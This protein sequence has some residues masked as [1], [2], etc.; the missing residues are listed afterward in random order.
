M[1]EIWSRIS[2][3]LVHLFFGTTSC[4]LTSDVGCYTRKAMDAYARLHGSSHFDG[5]QAN[6]LQACFQRYSTDTLDLQRVSDRAWEGFVALGVVGSEGWGGD[7]SWIEFNPTILPSI[8]DSIGGDIIVA[9]PC[10][11]VSNFA[12]YRTAIE[13]C[14]R[15]PFSFGNEQVTR[16]VVHTL[17]N[18]AFGSTFFHSSATLTGGL[19]DVRPI[20]LLALLFHQLAVSSLPYDPLLFDLSEIPR[21]ET[22]IEA[23]DTL[24][25]IL[26]EQD[27]SSWRTALAGMDVPFFELTFSAFVGV[28]LNLLFAESTAAGIANT[29]A[30]LLLSEESLDFVNNRVFPTATAAVA[31]VR[32]SLADRADLFLKFIGTGI[33]MVRR[34][35]RQSSTNRSSHLLYTITAPCIFMA[36]TSSGWFNTIDRNCHAKPVFQCT[37]PT[38]HRRHQRSFE[39][40]DSLSK[41]DCPAIG[42]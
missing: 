3:F 2:N 42:Y 21:T 14:E 24:S 23:A 29:T 41:G 1:G 40:F 34:I 13:V 22:G 30:G 35:C 7:G 26:L 39:L 10:N 6:R 33:K 18:L 38:N 12:Y 9:E 27:P 8:D 4:Q 15:Q 31:D 19:A 20:D 37:E 28:L 17:T 5:N 16:A 25:R 32:V 36:G 11:A